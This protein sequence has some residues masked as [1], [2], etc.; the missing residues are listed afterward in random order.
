MAPLEQSSGRQ[1]ASPTGSGRD[2]PIPKRWTT[3]DP[4]NKDK[5]FRRY[6]SGV[7]R[8]LSLFDTALQEWADYIS[9]LGRLLK[10]LQAHPPTVI[11]VPSKAIVAKRLAQCLNPS[12]P[13]GVHQKALEVYAYIFSMIGKDSLARDLP[14]YL[15]G[16]SS[17]LSFASL[18]VRSPFL[19]L[20]EKY[21]L[22]LDSRSLRP[23]LKAIIL[24]VLPGLEEETS[25]D[26]ERTITL[27]DG[28]KHAVR[29]SNS[30][31]LGQNHNSG[32]GYFWQCFFLAA[33]TSNGRRLGALAYLLRNLPKLGQPLA[34][35][36]A[37]TAAN[38]SNK[39]DTGLDPGRLAEL[40]TSPEPG[41]L[42]RCFAAGL[43]DEQLLIQR[44]FL[45]LLVTHLPLHSQV[46]Q[47]RVKKE[48]LELLITAAAG[49]VT[50][51]DM[52]LNRRLWTWLLG[53]EPVHND[54]EG[55]PE[56]PASVTA[57]SHGSHPSS[58]TH[59]F[60]QFGLRPLTNALLKMIQQDPINPVD[61]PRPFRICLSLMDRWEI[62]G[63]VV[64]DIFLPIVSSVQKYKTQASSK[65]EFSEVLR[66]A[67][68]FFD[69]VE[70]GLI[71]RE[72]VGL[73]AQAIGTDK[74]TATERINNL[75]LVNFIIAH[76][77]VR[78]E[79]MLMVHAPLTTLTILSMLED[80]RGK[81]G[82][83]HE[84]VGVSPEVS[85][86]ALSIAM[87]LIDLAPDRAFQTRPS[88]SQSLSTTDDG[89]AARTIANAEILENIK[90]FYT[91]DQGNL[92]AIGPPF[93]S[94]DVSEL[95]TRK[96]VSITSQD[97]S[98]PTPSVDAGMKSKLLMMVLSK[99]P[100]VK[101]LDIT[102]VISSM[103]SSLTVSSPVP[104]IVFTSITSLAT[105]LYSASY[106]SATDLSNLVDPLVRLAWSYLSASQPKYHV[107]T[108]RCLWQLQTSLSPSNREIESAICSLMV[109]RDVGGTFAVRDADSGRRFGVLWT[110]T[111]QDTGH[112]DQKGRKS[113]NTEAKGPIRLSGIENYGMMLSRPL[114]LL[115]DSLLDKHTQLF[116]TMETWLQTL[117]G[118][119][120]LFYLL[121]SKF[122]KFEFLHTASES[123]PSSLDG[124]I[125]IYTQEDDLD[126][127]SYYIR[128]LSNVLQCSSAHVWVVL[129][130]NTIAPDTNYT[131]LSSITGRDGEVTLLEF[132]LQVCL[133]AISGRHGPQSAS[134]ELV[135]KF[136]LTAL[137]TLQQILRSPSSLQLADLQLEHILI[138]RLTKSLDEPDSSSIQ[139]LLLK[140][141]YIS[142]EIRSASAFVAA[143]PTPTIE[144][145][146][147][148]A[149]D[150]PHNP[151]LSISTDRT[152]PHPP[153]RVPPPPPA[154]I[155]CLQAGFAASSS[156]PVLDN[157]ISF[158]TKCLPLYSDTIFQILIPLVE[159]FCRQ[160][161]RTFRS[162]QTTFKEPGLDTARPVA[163][164]STLIS[165]LNGLENVLAR[166]HDHLL[167]DELK[168]PAMKNPDQAQGFFGNMVSN[169][170][171]SEAPQARSASA[172]N[173]LTVLLSFQDAV[174]ICFLIWSWGGADGARQ[175][176]ESS[177]SFNY[178]SLRMRNRAR[179]LLE[180]LFAAETLECLETVV[181]MWQKSLASEQGSKSMVVFNLLHV[182]D[183]SR[184]KHT[185]PAIFN[186]IYSRSN[187][188]ALDPARKSTL[189][190]SLND[191]DLVIFL[192]EYTRSLEDDTMDEIWVDCMTFLKDLLTNPFPHRQTLP[193]LLEFAAILGEK[194]D[195]TNFG[196]QRKMRRDL[197][198]LFLRLLTAI[199]TT[200]PMGFL[201][202]T[203]D[204]V[205]R[206]TSAPQRTL[207]R[208]DD[209]VSILASIAS[210]LPKIL[211]EPDRVLS[212]ANIISTSVIGPTFKSK[213]FPDNVS[214]STLVLLYQLSRLPNTHKAWKKDVADAFND[215]KFFSTALSL[216]DSDWLPLLK[217]W[218][219]GEK[220]R[221]PELLSRMQAPTTA[222]I[223]FG[224]G[225]TSARLEA[226]RKTQLN[227]RRVATLV[228]ATTDDNFVADLPVIQEKMVELLLATTTSSP[229][230]TTRADVYLLLRAL[231]LKTSAVHLAT[232]WPII[233][234]ELHAAISSIVA[235]DHSAASD[236]YTNISILQACKLLDTL[237]C[238]APDDFQ[239][240]E[241]LFITDTI[242]AVYRPSQFH[243][244]A[245]ADAISEELG[246]TASAAA[247]QTEVSAMQ[248][249][250]SPTRKPLIGPGGISDEGNWERRDE[251]VAKVLRPFFGQLS[252]F[253]FESTYSMGAPDWEAC[254]MGVLKDL[255][256]ERTIVKAL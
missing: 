104:F 92:D 252:I 110:H 142:L 243:P 194:V 101:S 33:I 226:D 251:L 78:E 210:N 41:L 138:D 121:I 8:S 221:M 246:S 199:F 39:G 255:F 147:P 188:S 202:T 241:W 19:E 161:E 26:F 105:N 203:S 134:L 9:F 163:P 256:D 166:G 75:S 141:L 135:K 30:D 205:D 191:T 224:V 253:A 139:D 3:D 206:S 207:A 177:A 112:S 187:P 125:R 196:E 108:V 47:K 96:A 217:Q 14:L 42:L 118:I 34:H 97:L 153:P 220:E 195:N 80:T 149:Q 235:P 127:C 27:L 249:S 140:V 49:V 111:L 1:S 71:W 245:L 87:D 35:D 6:A 18:T 29:P 66:S 233:N 228:L 4:P 102:T 120:K 225:A 40:V 179:R 61:R 218:T 63:L 157:W 113:S 186:A 198:D 158:L 145:K 93:S 54:S 10:S 173:R 116:Q 76:F 70:S 240:L 107:E 168:T 171:T 232:L 51:R 98:G 119:E 48:D 62:G 182:L 85:K 82:K 67:S 114:F 151:R 190:S 201:E 133:R 214:K 88:T 211:V 16:L 150:T 37:N 7:E 176:V 55:G 204:A 254:R 219:L 69:G 12:L 100:R 175:D 229:S 72:I 181:D 231:A 74:A 95:L 15:P 46:L 94:R 58:P 90:A 53:P 11:T 164:E 32:D 183:G 68:V 159:T 162:L 81:N 216:V 213:A 123:G 17:T 65:T 89:E 170:F 208:S 60:E 13:S 155:N 189:T 115:L 167:H 237:L 234:A 36:G 59:Y 230:S 165:L 21:L 209:I 128:T 197:A 117:V 250:Q 137:T 248:T 103:H 185:I 122:L 129:A 38:G 109:E 57:S 212:A 136:Q 180:H 236:T 156:R 169:V 84:Y 238:I 77:N 174:R 44:G 223:V 130:E 99:I 24:S 64:P 73:I 25:E 126:G 200:R 192:V 22:K 124:P 31:D 43:A 215:S 45:D 79:E 144:H 227:L 239:L 242:D 86:M 193:S 222:G 28:F 247:I 20:L 50:R 5:A 146:R 148:S 172:N 184:P 131:A 23:A 152:D 154:L 178:T 143:P 56:S 83:E 2:S 106:I 244:I 160:I 91:E 52:S 132:F